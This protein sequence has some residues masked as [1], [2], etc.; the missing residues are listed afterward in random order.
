MRPRLMKSVWAIG[1]LRRYRKQ[2]SELYQCSGQMR[3]LE[4]GATLSITGSLSLDICLWP[5]SPPCTWAQASKLGPR[6][7][8]LALSLLPCSSFL[9]S[10]TQASVC[11]FI[12]Q[13]GLTTIKQG[14][15]VAVNVYHLMVSLEWNLE[16]FQAI[17]YTGAHAPLL[18]S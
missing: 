1:R 8:R 6:V 12:D 15:D 5:A 17:S 4:E 16:V 10:I 14:V 9:S 18:G 7:L 3:L 13:F 2:N 11:A